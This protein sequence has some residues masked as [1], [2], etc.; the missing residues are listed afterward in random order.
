MFVFTRILKIKTQLLFNNSICDCGRI[1]KELLVEHKY[2]IEFLFQHKCFR[3][4][5]YDIREFRI[6]HFDS[7]YVYAYER[8]CVLIDIVVTFAVKVAKNS[9]L[10]YCT[11]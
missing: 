9:V 4:I 1:K 5:P 8:R 2:F 7:A 11:A 6:E 10:R 3:I